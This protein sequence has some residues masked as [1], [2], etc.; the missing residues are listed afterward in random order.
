[1]SDAVR[2]ELQG[3][4]AVLRVDGVKGTNPAQQP[5]GSDAFPMINFTIS[6]ELEDDEPASEG[7]ERFGDVAFNIPLSGPAVALWQLAAERKEVPKVSFAAVD[8]SG[9]LL[10]RVDFEQVVVQ[11]MSIQTFGKR[12]VATGALRYHR[13][14]IRYGEGDKGFSASWDRVK[15]APWR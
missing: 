15:N 10:Y 7:S 14:R 12:N 5:L 1:M 2:F 11:S 8:P 4:V 9:A 6:T 13:M 3:P